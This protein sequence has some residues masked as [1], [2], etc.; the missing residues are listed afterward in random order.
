MLFK[1]FV[2]IGRV[3]AVNY[4]EEEGKLCVILDVVDGNRALVHG[5]TT[6]IPRQV[7]NF[8]R[9]SLT[10]IVVKG[11]TRGMREKCLKKRITEAKVEEQWAKTSTAKRAALRL[12]RAE[13]SDFDRFQLMLAKKRRS[14]VLRAS[15][16]K[17]TK[18][19][20]KK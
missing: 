5:P 13:A 6:G 4:G 8:K 9:L 12:K 10:D 1:K 20:A 15:L 19:A 2:Q 18:A 3:C 17:V 14:A 16:N 11:V 7:I